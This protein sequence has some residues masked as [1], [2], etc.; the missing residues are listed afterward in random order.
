MVKI[1]RRC[2]KHR[3]REGKGVY[4][5][6]RWYLPIPA[7]YKDAVKP[8]L[9]KDLEVEIKTVAN[10]RAHEKLALEKIKEE[11]EILELKKRVKE[12]EQDSKAFRDL[13]EVLRD[14][15]KMAKFKQLL[16]ED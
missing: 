6:Y 9:D 8:F 3:Y 2:C 14:P 10:A 7:K 4:T 12:M 5:Y 11:Q 15:E 13:V 16:E 1:Y